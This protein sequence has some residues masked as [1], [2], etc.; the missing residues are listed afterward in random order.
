MLLFKLHSTDKLGCFAWIFHN[1]PFFPK[2]ISFV[3]EF[4][5]LI[6]PICNIPITTYN[7]RTNIK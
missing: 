7:E 1:L 4:S 2:R 5:K 3:S 6:R